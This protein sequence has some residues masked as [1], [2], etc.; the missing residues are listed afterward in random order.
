M[1]PTCLHIST[2]YHSLIQMVPETS[3]TTHCL[4]SRSPSLFLWKRAVEKKQK[5][6]T[7]LNTVC[8][9]CVKIIHPCWSFC[10]QPKRNPVSLQ[11][12]SGAVSS[13]PSTIIFF[14]SFPSPLPFSTTVPISHHS[15]PGPSAALPSHVDR[16]IVQ[17]RRCRLLREASWLPR[18]EGGKMC[19]SC[20]APRKSGGRSHQAWRGHWEEEGEDKKREVCVKLNNKYNLSTYT[21]AA[22]TQGCISHGRLLKLFFDEVKGSMNSF[23]RFV[24]KLVLILN[25]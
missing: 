7:K 5:K 19:S 6:Q 14:P 8:K 10:V 2:L 20:Q 9:D 22:Q 12:L 25:V 3:F 15:P 17:P 11:S 4:F 13:F 24:F 21:D 16:L 1:I 23:V 18:W